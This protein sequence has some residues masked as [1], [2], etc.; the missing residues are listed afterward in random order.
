M[1]LTHRT[2]VAGRR[3]PP[4]EHSLARRGFGDTSSRKTA[5]AST[6]G[7]GGVLSFGGATLGLCL[8]ETIVRYGQRE[9]KSS[10][11]NGQE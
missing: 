4:V 2:L 7:E 10:S 6:D 1:H 9:N 5:P 3:A 11:V 8:G